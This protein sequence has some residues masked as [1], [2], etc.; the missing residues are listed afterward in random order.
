[1]YGDVYGWRRQGEFDCQWRFFAVAGASGSVAL[2]TD[3]ASGSYAALMERT[4][5]EG[6][7]GLD[8]DPL[9]VATLGGETLQ[10]GFASKKVSGTSDARI[11]LTVARRDIAVLI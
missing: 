11:R 5:A 9:R 6:D 10:V 2:D 8:I 3:A 7:S 1:L 4:V